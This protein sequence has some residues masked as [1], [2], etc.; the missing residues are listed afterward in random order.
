MKVKRIQRR[1]HAALQSGQW[2]SAKSEAQ[3]LVGLTPVQVGSYL[4]LGLA[5]VKCQNFIGALRAYQKA[6]Q[7]DADNAATWKKLV[8]AASKAGVM[9]WVIRGLEHLVRLDPDDK[10]HATR[11]KDLCFRTGKIDKGVQLCKKYGFSA[12]DA[13]AL[14]RTI[15]Q[16]MKIKKFPAAMALAKTLAK[17]TPKSADAWI[18]MGA[19]QY[20]QAKLDQAQACFEK[21]LKLNPQSV[22]AQNNLALVL[23]KTK[24]WDKA[25]SILEGLLQRQGAEEQTQ[26]VETKAV[27]SNLATAYEQQKQLKRAKKTYEKLLTLDADSDDARRKLESLDVPLAAKRVDKSELAAKREAEPAGEA[28]TVVCEQC[29][30][31]VERGAAFCHNCG[32]VFG[33]SRPCTNCGAPLPV[34]AEF[35]SRC[36]SAQ[37]ATGCTCLRCGA[38]NPTDRRYCSDCGAFLIVADQFAPER[39]ETC[40]AL[41]QCMLMRRF[42]DALDRCQELQRA[43]PNSPYPL[44]AASLVYEAANQPQPALDLC[45]QAAQVA[46]DDPVSSV[47]LERLAMLHIFHF[48]QYSE[49]LNDLDAALRQQPDDARGLYLTGLAHAR[50]G[51]IDE[52]LQAYRQLAD[53]P[54]YELLALAATSEMFAAHGTADRAMRYCSSVLHRAEEKAYN[55]DAQS[56]P[57]NGAD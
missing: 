46:S 33:H 42:Q 18:L 52:A 51:Q 36:G 23:L 17:L 57:A 4:L 40:R 38:D 39:A 9:A 45:A 27:L 35:C 29:G 22:V 5:E 16:A 14:V 43:E 10:S 20:R 49:A 41:E 56:P 48:G 31:S 28:D 7:L 37:A 32:A 1:I 53:D 2:A 54:R 44:L 26:P 11:L 55:G 21:A 34:D 13:K 50:L 19:A 30:A 25:S 6:V 8:F 15:N 24:Q 12:Q 3:D 47:A